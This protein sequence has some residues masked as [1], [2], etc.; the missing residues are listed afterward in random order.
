MS[1]VKSSL[2]ELKSELISLPLMQEFLRLRKLLHQ[3]ETISKLQIELKEAQKKLSKSV[4]DDGQYFA[5][6]KVYDSLNAKL[7]SN[8]LYVDYLELRSEVVSLLQEI[9][10]QLELI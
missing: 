5:C 6:K 1:D 7:H 4:Y 2:Q 8:P 10:D 9:K 3:D